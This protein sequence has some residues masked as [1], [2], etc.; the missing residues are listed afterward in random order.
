MKK[1][2]GKVRQ[3]G[4]EKGEP[5]DE[6]MPGHESLSDLKRGQTRSNARVKRVENV[7]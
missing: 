4:E 2:T 3:V 1:Q 5:T 7:R 6:P